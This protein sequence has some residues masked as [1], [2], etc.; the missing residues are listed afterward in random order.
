[1]LPSGSRT[2]GEFLAGHGVRLTRRWACV[3]AMQWAGPLLPVSE[4]IVCAVDVVS[5]ECV[6]VLL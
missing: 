4:I 3:G 1:M 5:V 2:C 6:V